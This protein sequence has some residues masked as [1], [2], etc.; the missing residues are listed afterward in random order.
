VILRLPIFVS[1][2]GYQGYEASVRAE[3]E[4]RQ[5]ACVSEPGQRP[6]PD[7]VHHERAG[8]NRIAGSHNAL[9]VR[10]VKQLASTGS[11]PGAPLVTEMFVGIALRKF[12]GNGGFVEEAA[13]QH[14]ATTGLQGGDGT[15]ATGGISGTYQVNPDCTGTSTLV[16]P[17]PFP[18]IVSDFVIV[19]N[20]KSIKEIV[21][22]PSA[23]IVTAV[24]TRK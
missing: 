10:A 17:A 7:R 1:F 11:P 5:N 21:T 24:Y 15:K 8:L 4:I 18:T 23:N 9:V 22:S 3:V 14:G 16:L 12:D 13:S 19:N 20:G 2:G 6:W